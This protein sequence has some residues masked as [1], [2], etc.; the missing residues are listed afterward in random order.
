MDPVHNTLPPAVASSL[1]KNTILTS[2]W[3]EHRAPIENKED[4]IPDNKN[5]SV[6]ITGLP[7]DITY[8]ALFSKLRGT[9][10]IWSVT[11]KPPTDFYRN[12]AA[13]VEYW[14]SGGLRRLFQKVIDQQ[15]IIGNARPQVTHSRI[16]RGPRLW[17]DKSRV[18]IVEGPSEIINYDFL[19]NFFRDRFEPNVDSFR[20]LANNGVQAVTWWAFIAYATQSARAEQAILDV[21]KN[22]D[23]R[24]SEECELWD[25][26]QLRYARDPCAL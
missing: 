11:I 12:A 3:R 10:K 13:H 5:C 1:A 23:D 8:P 2:N 18:L 17:S 6:W 21:Q 16:K 26:V 4:D 9:G 19:M 7:R 22:R 24:S 14:H 20:M 25:R 15:F